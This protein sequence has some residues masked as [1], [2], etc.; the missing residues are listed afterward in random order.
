[1]QDHVTWGPKHTWAPRPDRGVRRVL[2]PALTEIL[3]APVHKSVRCLNQRTYWIWSISY[4]I[5]SLLFTTNQPTTLYNLLA[6]HKLCCYTCLAFILLGLG[7]FFEN[8]KLLISIC[9]T[10]S[11]KSTSWF[12]LPACYKSVFNFVPFLQYMLVHYVH[13]NCFHDRSLLSA[14]IPGD[15][16]ACSTNASIVACHCP[17][18]FNRTDFRDSLTVSNL[19]WSTIFVF[20]RRFD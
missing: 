16:L 1:M 11:L 18:H 8:H 6:A 20:I 15:N 7:L 19:V 4:F 12:T 2:P 5:Y 14:F 17:F 3:I 10:L 9:I 13:Y